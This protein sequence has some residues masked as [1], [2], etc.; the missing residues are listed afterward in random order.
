MK[1]TSNQRSNDEPRDAS[2]VV[3]PCASQGGRAG[4]SPA[5]PMTPLEQA[6]YLTWLK[7]EN[8]YFNIK[9][10][11]QQTCWAGLF[12]F[13]FTTAIIVG[14][15]G[16]ECGYSDRWCYAT[17]REAADALGRWDGDGEPDG[18]HRHPDSGRRRQDGKEEIYF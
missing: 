17:A 3:K 10:I 16:D 15:M 6:T 12:Q 14:Q 7:L 5:P 11:R 4:R 18:W 8:G 9:P 1:T 13:A 2:L